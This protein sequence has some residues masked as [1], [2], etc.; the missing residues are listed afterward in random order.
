MTTHAETAKAIRQELKAIFPTVKFSITSE[1]FS[2]G[3][4]V[5]IRWEDGCTVEQVE[6]IAKKYQYGTFN[7]MEDLY[8]I[9]NNNDD[10]PQVKYVST[11]RDFSET[12][13]REAAAELGVDFDT[14]YNDLHESGDHNYMRIRSKMWHIDYT[15]TQLPEQVE[16]VKETAPAVEKEKR[17]VTVTFPQ[18]NKNESLAYNFE[19]MVIYGTNDE[20]CLVEK[21]VELSGEEFETVS[22][23]LLDNRPELWEQI[24][25]HDSDAPELEN[26]TY[27]QMCNSKELMEIFRATCYAYV[28]EVICKESGRKFYVNTEGYDYARYVGVITAKNRK[29]DWI[30]K[31]QKTYLF[32]NSN[33]AATILGKYEMSNDKTFQRL[34]AKYETARRVHSELMAQIEK[35]V[36]VV[37]LQFSG[38]LFSAQK[39]VTKAQNAIRKA[40]QNE[41]ITREQ[42]KIL[43]PWQ[44]FKFHLT[45]T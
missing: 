20:K 27:I 16:T 40:F 10:I 36:A 1:S 28:V 35:P 45:V 13:K 30:F 41:Q 42:F 9:D 4:A 2:M 25:G 26:C 17:F 3:N 15:N 37:S 19:A 8:E 11:S 44:H 14:E 23:S 33:P 32:S 21:T 29:D 22:N 6:S 18:L 7:G 34:K 24:G 12:R 43:L 31:P 39:D 38:M 5:R